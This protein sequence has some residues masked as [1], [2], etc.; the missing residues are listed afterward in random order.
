MLK[1]HR[2]IRTFTQKIDTAVNTIAR[3]YTEGYFADEDDFTSR[4]LE[5]IESELDD[6]RFGGITFQVRK[7]TWR[8]RRSE[9][10]VFGADI[11]AVVKVDLSEYKTN[12]GLLIQ[13]K[14]L[15]R[16]MMFDIDRWEVLKTQIEKMKGHTLDSYIWLYDSSGVRSI[17]AHAVT[18]LETRR[19]DDLYVTK[20][21]TFLGEFVQSKHGDP[22]ITDVR[23]LDRIRDEFSSK[24]VIS[25]SI[26][27]NDRG[28]DRV[29]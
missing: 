27:D 16:G 1:S 28:H 8:G 13:A 2:L 22:R 9:E 7:T 14:R 18:G 23:N 26:S 11:V 3:K 15:N 12:K 10:A 6:W 24:S 20:C 25:I 29:S 19:P 5:R 21:A 4:F 17:R